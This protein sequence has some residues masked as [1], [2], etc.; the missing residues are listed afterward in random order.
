MN[1]RVYVRE[2][3]TNIW[4]S[5]PVW[6]QPTSLPSIA[7]MP[8]FTT[9]TPGGVVQLTAT[10]STGALVTWAI[11]SPSGGQVTQSGTYTAPFAPGVYLVE[12]RVGSR[13]ALATVVVQ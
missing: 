11:A 1:E 12:A 5:T 13:L 8:A 2:V 10:V 7:I 6:V 4:A 9:T 3:S